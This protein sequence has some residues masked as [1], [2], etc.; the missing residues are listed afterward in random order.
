M[1]ALPS[2]VRIARG[3]H[4]ASLIV[5][6]SEF[7]REFG[8]ELVEAF[9][10][11]AE[12]AFRTRGRFGVMAL[13]AR[14]LLDNVMTAVSERGTL[15]ARVGSGEHGWRVDEREGGGEAMGTLIRDT[16]VGIR[17]L[18]ARP[19]F[20]SVAV[21]TLALGIGANAAIFSVVNGVLLRP[22][23]FQESQQLVRLY[24]VN[25]RTGNRR[26]SF[27][28]PDREDWAARTTPLSAVAVY[29]TSPS[30][31]LL[32]GGDEAVEV[33]TAYV[34]A[35]FFDVLGRDA[36]LGRVLLDSEER[37][38]NRVVVLS[39]DF[40]VRRF[41]ADETVVGGVIRLD[42]SAF[43][44]A[45]VMP[46][47]FVYPTRDVEVWVF[48][49]IIPP[50]SI[51]L[52]VRE[53]RFLEAIGRI[54]TGTTLEQATQEL[55]A[56][57]AALVAE[58]PDENEGL[59]EAELVPLRES[60]TAG[61][62]PTLFVLLGAVG[63]ILLIACA[64]VANL[65]LSRGVERRGELVIRQALGASRGRLIRQLMTESVLL[66]VAGGASGVAL[67]FWGTEALLRRSAGLLPRSGE[68]GIDAPVLMFSLAL[69][70]GTALAFGLLP[71]LNLTRHV[72]TDRL[73]GAA[74]RAGASRPGASRTWAVLVAS[75]VSLAM[76]I[77]IASGL[78]LRSLWALQSVDVGM[79]SDRLV[80]LSLTINDARYPERS[81]YLAAYE[82]L[83][84][85]LESLPGVESVGSI[86]YL[87][88]RRSGE[89]TEFSIAD[90]SEPIAGGPQR[91]DLLQVSPGFFRAAGVPLVA[92][93]DFT[94]QDRMDVAPVVII[95]DAL[96]RRYW[97][98]GTGVGRFLLFG[99]TPAEIVGVVGDIHQQSLAEDP[100][101]TLYF[102]QAQNP[103][104]GMAFV[105][106]AESDPESLLPRVRAAV[107]AIDPDQP[108]EHLAVMDDVV[109]SS[110]AQPRFFS[111]LLTSFA[112][113]ALLLASVGIYGVVS[114]SVSRRIPEIGIRVAL[115][116]PRAGV[117]GMVVASG[118][119]PVL[120]GAI[121]GLAASTVVMQ[122]LDTILF[123][124]RPLDPLTFTTVPLLL[125]SVALVACWLPARRAVRVDPTEAL[126]A[127]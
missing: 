57:S 99:G 115:G 65:L 29:S 98:G 89:S 108:I 112:V 47:D 44:V 7:R 40:W 6:P 42:D 53:V 5:H 113:L 123:G 48:L 91:A 12:E 86:R 96:R 8:A 103:R 16:L 27:S 46:P 70:V 114:H 41:G 74:G 102:A 84:E 85:R 87:P 95:N 26:G 79:E 68:I 88:L 3:L 100:R 111:L 92:G 38:Q 20:A 104:R 15:Q 61:V 13:L 67:A 109:Y 73:R 106:R 77:V 24:H 31:L 21:G 76:L 97:P 118:M 36:Y 55:S 59:E 125:V 124:V 56:V 35:G 1:T 45:G 81:D 22:L 122:V 82:A 39:H 51:P 14:A 126:R 107:H 119:R 116:A 90:R 72:G 83:M 10:L 43:L 64:N 17:M 94:R 127:Q 78:L 52:D 18:A 71:A 117:V 4:R 50:S 110:T 25:A 11:R 9:T 23:P 63:L 37:G 30:G 121:V 19:V 58:L 54:E 32:T 2:A 49:T 62:E 80:A 28:L 60:M 33:R 69:T 105:V 34:S 66:S 101:P 93:R 75:Q 120:A